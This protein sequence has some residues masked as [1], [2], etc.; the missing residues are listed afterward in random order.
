MNDMSVG[1]EFDPKKMPDGVLAVL[2]AECDSQVS[3]REL[4]ERFAD[5]MRRRI[6]R[7]AK[8]F[9]FS[10]EENEDARQ[11]A[12]VWFREAL[13]TYDTGQIARPDGNKFGSHLY[14]VLQ[15]RFLNFVR[16]LRHNEAHSDRSASPADGPDEYSEKVDQAAAK[17][18]PRGTNDPAAI[19]ARWE[20]AEIVRDTLAHSDDLTQKIWAGIQSD[21]S[22]REIAQELGISYHIVKRRWRAFK[23]K[24]KARLTESPQETTDTAATSK[25][26]KHRSKRRRPEPPSESA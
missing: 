20:E 19:A 14:L 9:R 22:E 24:L 18:F 23:A 21:K 25:P 26:R 2:A 4:W 7:L 5:R 3:E 6:A 11:Q 10:R 16:K 17:S 1:C 15:R 13:A 12:Y 8:K